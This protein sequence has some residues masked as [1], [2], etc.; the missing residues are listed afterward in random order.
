MIISPTNGR[1]VWFQPPHHGSRHTVQIDEKVLLTAQVCH[2]F[3]DRCVNLDVTD[4]H[5][6]HHFY[7][8]VTLLQDEDLK[9]E[10]GRFAVWM[11]YQVGQAKKHAA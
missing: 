9:P 6:T 3:G 1:I 11:P 7:S 2:V 10:E 4:S 8:S 5:G